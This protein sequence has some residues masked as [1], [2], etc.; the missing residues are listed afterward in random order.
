MHSYLFT[1]GLFNFA[2]LRGQMGEDDYYKWQLCLNL[3]ETAGTGGACS[4]TRI[5]PHYL[6]G[7]L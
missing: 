5:C 7:Q 6:E 3:G 2:Y 4:E 1:A